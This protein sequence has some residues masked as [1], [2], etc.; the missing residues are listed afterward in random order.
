MIR[1]FLPLDVLDI[2][3]QGRSLSNK[4]R[5]K[6]NVATGITFF[7]GLASL[8]GQWFSPR[9][10]FCVW[11]CSE[12]FSLRGLSSVRDR[13]SPQAWEVDRLLL[14]EQDGDCCLALLEQVSLA[15]G[16]LAVEK[17]FLRLPDTS[18][19]LSAAEQSGFSP[20]VTERLY[21]RER[22]KQEAV[23]GDA[24][25]GES[26]AVSP[27]RRRQVDDD[28]RLFELYQR[29]IPT[30]VRRVEGATFAQWKA[31]RDR[32]V[33]QEWVFE[34]GGG[35]VGWA[36]LD[37]DGERGRL[38]AT[39]I[40][41]DELE[42]VLEYGLTNLSGCRHLFCLVPE[43]EQELLRMLES[44]GFSQVSRYSVLSKDLLARAQ[45]PCLVPAGA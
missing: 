17:V 45:E 36:A 41:D 13:S 14:R 12:G 4:A 40:S 6:D 24:P 25:A 1:A 21:W 7:G 43:F 8:L 23:V 29:R 33:G 5:T 18:P 11:V 27:P 35:L 16:E 9:G 2:A 31:N 26:S 38:E 42:R 10:R 39:A 22:E 19:L 28:Y 44:R 30:P 37:T 3:L 20:Y 34:K 15:G 32:S